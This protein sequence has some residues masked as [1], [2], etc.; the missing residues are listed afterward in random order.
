MIYLS[1]MGA[2]WN[3]YSIQAFL[4]DLVKISLKKLDLS[5]K[6]TVSAHLILFCT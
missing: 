1:A 3:G 5:G 6:N 2:Y 4:E